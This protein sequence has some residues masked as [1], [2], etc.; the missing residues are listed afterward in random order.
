MSNLIF[1]ELRGLSW[2]VTKTP[3]FYTLTKTSPTGLDVSAVLSAFPRWHFSLSY[4]FLWDDSTVRGELQKLMGLFLSCYGNVEDFL[5]RDPNDYKVQNELIGSGDGE[6]KE[7]QL[8]RTY[9]GFTEPIYAIKDTP[10]V[11]VNG[12]PVPFSYTS[13]GVIKFENPPA[14]QAKIVWSGEFY[15]RVKFK[16]S[17][18]EFNN[19]AYQLWEAKTVEFATVKKVL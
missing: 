3:E 10:V 4:E 1:P 7:F 8:C 2:N 6:S 5:Y 16:E 15:Y 19:F 14:K 13:K 11:A 17:S 12:I 9:A 18:M